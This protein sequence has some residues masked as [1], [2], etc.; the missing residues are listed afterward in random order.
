MHIKDVLISG[1]DDFLAK[2]LYRAIADR[3]GADGQ[4]GQSRVWMLGTGDSAGIRADIAVKPIVMPAVMQVV[5]H[6]DGTDMDSAG[7][8]E[9]VAMARVRNLTASLPSDSRPDV[10][11]YISSVAV[12][13]SRPVEYADEGTPAVPDT[14]YG[15]AKLAV[16]TY[17]RGWC[18]EAGTVLYILRP[19]MVVGTGMQGVLRRLVNRI[20]R[21]TY[22]H[23]SGNDARVSVVHAST[24]ADVVAVLMYLRDGGIYNVTDGYEPSR[25]DL[26]EALAWRLDHKRIYTVSLSKARLLAKIGDYVPV[27]MFT[28]GALEKEMESFTFDSHAIFEHTGVKPEAVTYYLCNHK[29]DESSL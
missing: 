11:I 28:T 18:D 16:E 10:F 20:Y 4:S 14:S 3:I 5:V 7:L 8:D 17:L 19:A 25:H 21:G 13:G 26:A 29:Y 12:Y 6:C 22:R 2:Y 27:T 9:D 15:R 23:V 24:L 1:G